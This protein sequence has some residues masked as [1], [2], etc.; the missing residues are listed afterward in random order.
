VSV[1][2][3]LSRRTEAQLKICHSTFPSAQTLPE[4]IF[5]FQCSSAVSTSTSR[6]LYYQ[7]KSL[8]AFEIS[9]IPTQPHVRLLYGK[10]Q[11]GS[12]QSNSPQQ[13]LTAIP[14]NIPVSLV[15]PSQLT[16]AILLWNP[17]ICHSISP[18]CLLSPDSWV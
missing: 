17:D 2:I 7:N 16:K 18:T 5:I 4:C 15:L 12:V 11:Q 1:K 9:E 13:G 14:S 8:S 3:S 10:L 6:Q